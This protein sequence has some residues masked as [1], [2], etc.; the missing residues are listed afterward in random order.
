ML[1]TQQADT[2]A[3]LQSL[4]QQAIERP[5]MDPGRMTA[6]EKKVEAHDL[7]IGK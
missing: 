6:M 2:T 7:T 1:R 3:T 5:A 4:S